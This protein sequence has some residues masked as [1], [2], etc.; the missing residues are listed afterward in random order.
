MMD[1]LDT[2]S[3]VTSYRPHQRRSSAF[4]IPSNCICFLRLI[5]VNCSRICIPCTG[6]DMVFIPSSLSWIPLVHNLLVFEEASSHVERLYPFDIQW[7]SIALIWYDYTLTFPMEVKYIWQRKFGVP[8]ALY[9]L[10]RYAL[11]ANILYLLDIAGKLGH[12]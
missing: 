11:V 9:I 3:G 8:T 7:S 1:T 4:A 10:C 6:L 12:R 5:A 2:A